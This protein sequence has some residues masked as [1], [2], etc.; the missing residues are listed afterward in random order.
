MINYI[1]IH[2]GKVFYPNPRVKYQ[3]YCK[4][5]SCQNARR[6][7]WYREKLVKDRDYRENQRRCQK[8]WHSRH[9]CYYKEYRANHPE[10]VNRNRLLQLRRNSKRGKDKLSRMIAKIDSLDRAFFSR[11]GE[12]FK[13]IPQESRMIAK[14]DSFIVNFIPYKELGGYG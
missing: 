5:E 8:D 2:C 6:N 12:L 9:P 4:D 10:Y 3:R 1:C 11:K 14:I 7:R 13:L